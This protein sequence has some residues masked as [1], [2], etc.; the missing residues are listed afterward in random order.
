MYVWKIKADY[1]EYESHVGCTVLA[2]MCLPMALNRMSS[3]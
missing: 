1:L 2:A 3:L